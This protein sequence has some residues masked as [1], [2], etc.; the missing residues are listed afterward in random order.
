MVVKNLKSQ[1]SKKRRIPNFAN[2]QEM[3]EWWDT[4]EI[5]DYLDELKSVELQFT[6]DFKSEYRGE[7]QAFRP[8]KTNQPLEN[9][10]IRLPVDAKAEL[11]K[12]AVRKGIGLTTLA[13]ILVVEGLQNEDKRFANGRGA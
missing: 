8:K 3:A 11:H 6:D 2:R 13:R 4:H 1:P 5:T 7:A 12:R 9:I 10:T